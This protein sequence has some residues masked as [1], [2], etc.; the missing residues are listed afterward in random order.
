M[1]HTIRIFLI[2]FAMLNFSFFTPVF[3]QNET[4]YFD[5]HNQKYWYL[6]YPGVTKGMA[7]N[8]LWSY[9]LSFY[10]SIKNNFGISINYQNYERVSKD[11]PADF[12]Y[13]PFFNF[14]NPLRYAADKISSYD[15]RITKIFPIQNNL[16]LMVEAGAGGGRYS[17]VY[18]TPKNPG[19]L[20]NNNYSMQHIR[21]NAIGV[22]TK[23]KFDYIITRYFGI[24]TGFTG[25]LNT[26]M[27]Y[28]SFDLGITWGKLRNQL[29][30]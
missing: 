29:H 25:N 1:K 2:G 9:Q 20:S 8:T 24:S 12:R 28:V 4:V 23:V 17:K 18:F 3:A 14:E 22:S 6:Q 7:T 5:I 27:S 30:P 13:E 26:Q 16:R 15:I 11:K 21:S 19:M 10:H